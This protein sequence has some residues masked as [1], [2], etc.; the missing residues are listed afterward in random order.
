MTH[1]LHL[2]FSPKDPNPLLPQEKSE[3][4]SRIR[5]LDLKPEIPKR[6]PWYKCRS[7]LNVV[8][9]YICMIMVILLS[10]L[11]FLAISILLT[12]IFR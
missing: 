8:V 7:A 6:T 4:K 5:S 12:I 10:G 2:P 9:I 11:V 3:E 1:D